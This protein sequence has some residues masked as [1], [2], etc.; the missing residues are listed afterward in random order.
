MPGEGTE[1]LMQYLQTCFDTA[2]DGGGGL[3][4]VFLHVENGFGS[5]DHSLLAPLL[6]ASGLDP[7]TGLFFYAWKG[8]A[9]KLRYRPDSWH[10]M[11]HR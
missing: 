2:M 5:V 9:A 4:G 10:P 8:S 11:P 6:R 7:S 1:I 3:T